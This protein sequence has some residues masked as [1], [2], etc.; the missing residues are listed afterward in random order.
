MK[1]KAQIIQA[2]LRTRTN[3][4]V[5]HMFSAVSFSKQV[6]LIEEQNKGAVF[7]AFYED[8]FS[9]STACIFS[10]VASLESYINEI[11]IDGGINFPDIRAEVME[12]VWKNTDKKPILEKY[13]FALLLK[14]K[15]L[16]IKG[17]GLY[18]NVNL[19]INLRN[20][21]IHFKPEWDGQQSEHCK[22]SA[23]LQGKFGKSPFMENE[24]FL[25]KAWASYECTNWAVKSCI[26]FIY[27]FEN[28]FGVESCFDKFRN[29]LTVSK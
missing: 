28:R 14:K 3:F 8:V 18:Q 22:I 23:K 12:E 9:Y 29:R 10:V 4:S 7:G 6:N 11:Y 5:L 26:D 21:L 19:V 17:D 20:T 16:L 13:D 15:S 24:S 2:T 25:P 27:D 1:Q